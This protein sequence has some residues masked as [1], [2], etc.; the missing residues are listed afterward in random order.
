MD[1]YFRSA[2]NSDVL[3]TDKPLKLIAFGGVAYY[4][5][6]EPQSWGMVA[7]IRANGSNISLGDAMVGKILYS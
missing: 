6:G 3:W 7:G 4:N 5:T 2:C 1:W